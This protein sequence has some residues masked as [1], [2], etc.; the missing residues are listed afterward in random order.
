MKISSR[1]LNYLAKHGIIHAE[2]TRIR[3]HITF[4]P[5]ITSTKSYARA[6]DAGIDISLFSFLLSAFFYFYFC[7]F[8][9]SCNSRP[10]FASTLPES[11]AYTR[12]NKFRYTRSSVRVYVTSYR[13]T[14]LLGKRFPL[15]GSCTPKFYLNFKVIPRHENGFTC[16]REIIHSR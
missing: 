5:E 9:I 3:A 4:A 16:C 13:R 7:F 6:R 1:A 2:E 11:I 8:F 10:V 14:G 12:L 15:Y